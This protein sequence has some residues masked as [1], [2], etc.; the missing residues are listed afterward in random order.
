[1]TTRWASKLPVKLV[2]ETSLA[3]LTAFLIEYFFS[4][5]TFFFAFLYFF[6][7]SSCPTRFR[8][9]SVS[10]SVFPS[11]S[12]TSVGFFPVPPSTAATRSPPPSP[13]VFTFSCFFW[14]SLLSFFFDIFT[15]TKVRYSKFIIYEL[16]T[17]SY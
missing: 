9:F 6:P 13:V 17:T 14:S 3:S 2:I 5:S 7:G 1:M 15:R 4:G 10:S 11:M 12:S 8:V 16:R